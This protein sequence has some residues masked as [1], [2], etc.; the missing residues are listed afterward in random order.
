MFTR[1]TED[2]EGV[3]FVR[4]VENDKAMEPEPLDVAGTVTE[5]ETPLPTP[6]SWVVW[7]EA[8]ALIEALTLAG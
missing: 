1:V 8:P 5:P 7:D 3:P 2:T 6:L 4:A